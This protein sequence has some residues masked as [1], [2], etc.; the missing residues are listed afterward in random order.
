MRNSLKTGG[1]SIAADT[2]T[3]FTDTR[4]DDNVGQNLLI[5]DYN[6]RSASFPDFVLKLS[7]QKAE[8][9][10]NSNIDSNHRTA[11]ETMHLDHLH[12]A[13]FVLFIYLID[14]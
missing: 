3:Q 12:M 5:F 6:I 4:H 10:R 9:L 13:V 14:T 1:F 7:K 2:V 8:A 11:T